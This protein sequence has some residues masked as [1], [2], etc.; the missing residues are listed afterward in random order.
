M[1]P[2]Q[3]VESRLRLIFDKFVELGSAR[4]VIK[5]LS[6][7]KLLVPTRQ[8]I[9]PVPDEIQWSLPRYSN[10]LCILHNPAYAGAY[11]YGRRIIDAARSKPGQ[12]H[13]GVIFLPI[14]KWTVCIRDHYP[15]YITWETYMANRT[16]LRSNRN[17]F[18]KGGQ[19]APREGKALLQGIVICGRCGRRL[20]M[21]Y[22]GSQG[23]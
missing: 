23:E 1:N 16:R 11:V 22:S 2:D 17:E 8:N 14:D 3:E 4:T 9:G 5:Y 10:I 19:G 20:F 6:Q 21:G 7:Q 18:D 15:A 12:P 13:S